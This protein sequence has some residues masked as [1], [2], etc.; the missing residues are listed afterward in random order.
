MDV[1][2]VQTRDDD[3]VEVEWIA[4]NTLEVGTGK[5]SYITLYGNLVFQ[6]KGKHVAFGGGLWERGARFRKRRNIRNKEGRSSTF[7]QRKIGVRDVMPSI[8][9]EP[10]L[11]GEA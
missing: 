8:H 7:V 5:Y 4:C 9:H 6:Y 3:F 10:E 11:M 2:Y 1:S